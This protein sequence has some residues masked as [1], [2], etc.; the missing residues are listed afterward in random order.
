MT[1][2]PGEGFIRPAGDKEDVPRLAVE[3]VRKAD[4]GESAV[5][6]EAEGSAVLDGVNSAAVR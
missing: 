6:V 3:F 2:A 5:P 1:A 4:R